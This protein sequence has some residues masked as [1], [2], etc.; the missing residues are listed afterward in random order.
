PWASHLVSG[1][2]KGIE[3]RLGQ[4]VSACHVALWSGFRET[5]WRFNEILFPRP[6]NNGAQ[7]V[8]GLV[9]GSTGI[10]SL[11]SDRMPVDPIQELAN[12]FSTKVLDLGSATPFL[13]LP[14]RRLVL[15]PS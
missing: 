14:E 10:C 4:I 6:R 9:R 7:V 12:L 5:R 15:V 8:A 3:L 1:K 11:V 13:P 2:V